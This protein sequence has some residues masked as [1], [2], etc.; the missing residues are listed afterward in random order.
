MPAGPHFGSADAAAGGAKKRVAF[1][2]CSRN[3][4]EVGSVFEYNG[5]ERCRSA[6]FLYGG[7]KKCSG[8]CIGYGDCAA[9]CPVDAITMKD[10]L[11]AI[12]AGRCTGCG[13]CVAQCPK[14]IIALI[15]GTP[16]AVEKKRCAEYCM[17][18]NLL[19]RVDQ[20]QCKKCG[21]CFKN[22]PSGAIAWEKG[23]SAFIDKEKCTQCLTCLRLCPPKVIS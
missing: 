13:L 4:S 6:M 15:A 12:D 5:P 18:D 21:I 20:E 11:P 19:F 8:S 2:M 16:A 1:L 17:Q 7:G 3:V 10:D 22:C 9:V 14:K 23:Q